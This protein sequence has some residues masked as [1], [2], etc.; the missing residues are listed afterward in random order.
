MDQTG[1]SL[2]QLHNLPWSFAAALCTLLGAPISP[3]F[4]HV[5]RRFCTSC[6]SVITLYRLSPSLST[7]S[8]VTNSLG[9]LSIFS[10]QALSPTLPLSLSHYLFFCTLLYCSYHSVLNSCLI[11]S[12]P[13]SS[14][15]PTSISVSFR[16]SNFEN[17]PAGACIPVLP[18]SR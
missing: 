2:G 7:V 13:F 14:S 4:L 11:L 15:H 16:F 12:V 1:P 18:H 3:Y 8:F 6:L 17:V 9:S 5:G 10:R